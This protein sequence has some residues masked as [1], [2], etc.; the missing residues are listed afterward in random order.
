MK[1][2]STNQV[3]AGETLYSEGTEN[4]LA[5]MVLK[6]KV[7]LFNR[8]MCISSGV[9]TLLGA[10]QLNGGEDICSVRIAEDASVYAISADSDKALNSLFSANRDYCGIA[11]YNHARILYELVK[12][13]NALVD[14]ASKIYNDTKSFYDRYIRFSS[15]LSAKAVPMPEIVQLKAWEPETVP[16]TEG[17]AVKYELLKIPLDTVKAFF[18]PGMMLAREAITEMIRLEQEFF[19]AGAQI[20]DYIA[21]LYMLLVGDY[22]Y[23]LYRNILGLAIDAAPGEADMDELMKMADTC[24]T[25]PDLISELIVRGTSRIWMFDINEIRGLKDIVLKGEDFRT[26]DT[27]DAENTAV[28]ADVAEAL[29]S[30]NDSFGQIVS[31]GNYPDAA[32][33]EFNGLLEAFEALRDKGSTDDD[34]RKMKKSIAEHY[35]ALYQKVF[36]R[37]M[38]EPNVPKAVD[39][40]LNYGYVSEKLLTDDQ[41]KELVSIGKNTTCEPCVVYTMRQWLNEIYNGRKIPSRNDLGQDYAD[42]LREMR[43]SGSIDEVQEKE[44][45]ENKEKRVEH[46]IK[47]VMTHSCMIVNGQILSFVPILYSDAFVGTVAKTYIS[48]AKLNEAFKQL[49]EIDYSVFYRETLFVDAKNGIEREYEMKEVLPVFILYPVAGQN[50]IMWQ[51]ITGRK[52]DTEGR[53]FAPSFSWVAIKD[54]M[55]K[56]FGQFRWSLCKTIQGTNWNNIQVRS[57]TSEYSD[58]I[59]FYKKNHDLSEERKEKVKMQIQKGRGNLREIFTLDYEIWMKV[60]S[61]GAI[62][63]NKVARDLLATYCPFSAQIKQGLLRQVTFEDAFA[64]NDRERSKKVHELELRYRALENKGVVLPEQLMNTLKFYRDM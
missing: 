56:A 25:Y 57:L 60:E 39:L 59:Q 52:R 64:R 20:S 55:I 16:N 11:V 31:F 58:Y 40:F 47:S 46:E 62:K 30:L 3:A 18:G 35:Y 41:L 15:R 22:D 45:L 54:M 2:N 21:S 43:K 8:G 23:S 51:E 37:S 61:T 53:F 26:N 36:L 44:L 17:A 4:G 49:T 12:K 13:Y 14:C 63:L 38:N 28:S 19:E 5:Y 24:L 6:G 50:I 33:A 10:E 27:N 42:V 34:V 1:I 29:S 32:T 7:E 9:G 48:A